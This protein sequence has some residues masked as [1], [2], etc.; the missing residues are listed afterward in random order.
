MLTKP[1]L[2]LT[3]R[4]VV[5]GGM[6]LNRYSTDENYIVKSRCFAVIVNLMLSAFRLPVEHIKHLSGQLLAPGVMEFGP[7]SALMSSSVLSSTWM[8]Y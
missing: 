2:G 8:S 4:L 3:T 7:L 6:F 5:I 1:L